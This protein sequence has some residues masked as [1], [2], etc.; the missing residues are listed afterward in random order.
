[1]RRH[2]QLSFSW[3]KKKNWKKTI[4]FFE[5]CPF[6]W[7]R[8]VILGK[9]KSMKDCSSSDTIFETTKNELFSSLL[10]NGYPKA[11][12]N[13]IFNDFENRKN[14]PVNEKEKINIQMEFFSPKISK[15]FINKN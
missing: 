15:I 9:L 4:N 7:K 13:R 3:Y 8:S 5:N 1:M 10:E 11:I 12:I 14:P 6:T 2:N